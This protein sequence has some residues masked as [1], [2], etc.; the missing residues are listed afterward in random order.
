M[1]AMAGVVAWR[2]RKPPTGIYAV[3]KW[4]KIFLLASYAFIALGVAWTQRNAPP[5]CSQAS[6][7]TALYAT[8][9]VAQVAFLWGRRISVLEVVAESLIVTPI[10][11]GSLVSCPCSLTHEQSASD[12]FVAAG[13]AVFLLGT[14]ANMA[15][16]WWR[17][18]IQV[19]DKQ[20]V[21]SGP[22]AVVRHPNYTAEIVSFIGFASVGG[23]QCWY[24]FV[25]PVTITT[26]MVVWLVEDLERHLE[27]VHGPSIIK[28]W[29]K[30]TRYKLL[31]A[32][33]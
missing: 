11:L 2:T 8:R 18:A 32:V 12:A 10:M 14:V 13:S 26:I 30:T 19:C 5:A 4:S 33:W 21:I 1:T 27:H 20:L 28:E 17:D 7:M 3:T 9:V 31:P 25:I 23:V 15:I 16:E 22:F 29:K 6:V 24:N